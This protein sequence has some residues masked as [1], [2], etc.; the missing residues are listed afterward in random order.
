M[1][2]LDALH[3]R[4][5]VGLL[6]EPAPDADQRQ[7]IFRAALRA[8]DHGNLRPWR[9]LVVEGPARARLGEIYLEATENKE[10][11]SEAQLAR[12]LAMPL[13]APLV[14]VAITQ[15]QEHP[16]VPRNEQR[17]STAGAVQAMLT[18]AF[19]ENVGAYWRTGALAE[20]RLVARALGL[21]DNEEISGFIYMGTPAKP[22]RSAPDLAVE[23]FF[24]D[25]AGE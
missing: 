7:N 17:M 18:A 15:L 22:P 21:A 4:V 19:A 10:A 9:F 24:A 11:L 6:T 25:W 16:K 23:D 5:S 2:A 20:N 1:D 8:A 3:N 13:R 14:I 12:I